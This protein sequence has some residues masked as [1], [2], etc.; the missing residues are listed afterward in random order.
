M[1]WPVVKLVN[2]IRQLPPTVASMLW[3][4]A[5]KP[6][7]GSHLTMASASSKVQYTGW[8]ARAGHGGAGWRWC[9]WSAPGLGRGK[10]LSLSLC[11]HPVQRQPESTTG[12]RSLI[13]EDSARCWQPESY[14][15]G[16][17]CQPMLRCWSTGFLRKINPACNILTTGRRMTCRFPA[18]AC[19]LPVLPRLPRPP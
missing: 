10:A 15:A 19:C 12:E 13:I 6:F 1:L 2:D 3:T 5:V 7:G 17:S 11:M 9:S 16:R 18:A 4:L 14:R 8:G